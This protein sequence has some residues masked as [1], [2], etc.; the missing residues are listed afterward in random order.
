MQSTDTLPHSCENEVFLVAV[1][2]SSRSKHFIV[3]HIHIIIL[4]R[5]RENSICLH[6]YDFHQKIYDDITY[7]SEKAEEGQEDMGWR[8]DWRREGSI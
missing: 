8:K 1:D 5:M 6:V 2:S 4:E 3:S 7:T